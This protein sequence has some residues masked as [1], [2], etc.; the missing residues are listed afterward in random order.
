MAL[1]RQLIGDKWARFARFIFS[2]RLL[3][4][5]CSLI[6]VTIAI[7]QL[8]HWGAANQEPSP[9]DVFSAP[10]LLATT[11][12][13]AA[14]FV[15]ARLIAQGR[16]ALVGL[17]CW[18]S[19]RRDVRADAAPAHAMLGKGKSLSWLPSPSGAAL[20]Y[21]ALVLIA[22]PLHPDLYGPDPPWFETTLWWTGVSTPND[23]IPQET[24]R[25]LWCSLLLGVATIIGWLAFGLHAGEGISAYGPFVLIIGKM[26]KDVLKVGAFFICILVGFSSALLAVS[27][28][29][30]DDGLNT[31]V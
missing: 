6:S 29:L 30:E 13:M 20:L 8:P 10:A 19:P 18:R 1:V 3:T 5:L 21:V 2:L 27:V 15:P 17:S 11:L 26:F 14:V 12:A 23:V 24:V 4:F 9:L 28:H 25:V 16:E 7:V 22:A 31:Q